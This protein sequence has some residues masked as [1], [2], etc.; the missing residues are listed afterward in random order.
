MLSLI[1]FIFDDPDLCKCL[2]GSVLLKDWNPYASL[3]G[4]EDRY[5]PT[6]WEKM[7]LAELT[8]PDHLLAL[9]RSAILMI[10]DARHKTKP[11]GGY[12]QAPHV[13]FRWSSQELTF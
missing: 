4:K 12:T 1:Q 5:S 10:M 2:V 8:F 13:F 11:L 7:F 9:N 3:M 6:F